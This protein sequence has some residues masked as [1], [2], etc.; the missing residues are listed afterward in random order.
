MN[1]HSTIKAREAA[2]HIYSLIV[3]ANTLN[4]MGDTHIPEEEIAEYLSEIL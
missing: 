2:A 3:E 4:D 1:E